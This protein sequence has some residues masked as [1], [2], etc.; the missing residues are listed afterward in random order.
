VRS[1]VRRAEKRRDLEPDE[2][3]EPSLEWHK[4][5]AQRFAFLNG[6][7]PVLH[8][9]CPKRQIAGTSD[10]F[11]IVRRNE[12]FAYVDGLKPFDPIVLSDLLNVKTVA[13]DGLQEQ[14]DHKPRWHADRVYS[15]IKAKIFDS[16]TQR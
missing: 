8:L 16:L 4:V 12:C 5:G 3:Q 9:K 11:E 2:R 7:G 14:W 6:A 13:V 15:S 1:D 10:D